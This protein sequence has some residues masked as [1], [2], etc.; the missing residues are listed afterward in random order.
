MAI[1]AQRFSVRRQR[2]P[3]NRFTFQDV[4]G[5][6]REWNFVEIEMRVRV[7]AK[8]GALIQP[9]IKNLSQ[10]S[11]AELGVTSFVHETSDGNMLFPKR[12]QEPPGCRLD[13]GEG[14]YSGVTGIRQVIDRNRDL[15]SRA[16]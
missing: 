12:P 1:I 3:Q 5:V 2:R 8:V 14:R 16:D 11:R 7:V 6:P 4:V 9:E 15:S 10:P 13:F